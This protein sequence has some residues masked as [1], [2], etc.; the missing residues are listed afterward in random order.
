MKVFFCR[1]HLFHK[2]SWFKDSAEPK[3]TRRVTRYDLGSDF[4]IDS[5]PNRPS[6]DTT[7][8]WLGRVEAES[9]SSQSKLLWTHE[10]RHKMGANTWSSPLL[11]PLPAIIIRHFIRRRDRAID[12]LLQVTLPLCV[13][14]TPPLPISLSHYP[15]LV[16][17]SHSPSLGPRSLFLSLT[18]PLFIL[19]IYL[20]LIL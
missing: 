1:W 8:G 6:P 3:M 14:L 13:C 4:F 18:P 9:A 15:S 19:D 10:R 20:N 5:G 2:G 16:S 11:S 7:W 17:L 12:V